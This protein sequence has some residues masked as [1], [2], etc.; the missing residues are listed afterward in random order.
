MN[1]DKK[2]FRDKFIEF[3]EELYNQGDKEL[4]NLLRQQKIDRDKILNEVGMILLR[5]DI[6]DTS[7]N[8]SH[9]EYIKEYKNL[10]I[11]ISNVFESQYNGEKVATDKLLKMIAE[12]KYYSN[13]FLLSLGL[14][15]KLNKMKVKDIKKILDATIEGKNYSDRIWSN[16]NK[17]AKVIKK[18]MKDFLQGNTN[19]NDIYKVVKDRFN[20]SAYITRRLV[21]NEVARV[22]EE[23]NNQWQEDNNIEW[24]LYDGTLDDKICGECQQYDGKTYKAD[25]KPIDLPQHVHCRCTYISLPSKDYKP[26]SRINNISK[27]DIDWTTYKEWKEG[28]L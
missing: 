15:F 8:L 22:Q 23:V 28:S 6:K 3:A 12:D 5:Y 27:K 20:Q 13:S 9:A 26:R 16:K 7:L 4:L 18:E 2:L 21:Q 14:D 1:K 25:E 10:D 19:V 24:V 11:L 17:V